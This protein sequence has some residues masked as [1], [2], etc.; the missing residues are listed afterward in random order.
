MVLQLA[1]P[2]HQLPTFYG[3]IMDEK[4]NRTGDAGQKVLHSEELFGSEKLVLIRHEGAT[5]R[6]MITRQGKLILTK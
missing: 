5:Y 2:A 6:L 3:C 4:K 1:L